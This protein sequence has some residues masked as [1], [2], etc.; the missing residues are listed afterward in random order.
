MPYL[1]GTLNNLAVLQQSKNDY[2]DALAGYQEALQIYR[3]LAKDNP[4][5]YLPYVAQTLNNLAGLQK[6]K[7]E[8]A[9]ALA[10]YQESLQIRRNLAIAHKPICLMWLPR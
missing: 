7:N 6:A 8:F 2:A 9:Q 3:E 10:N 1:V 5:T 4:Q